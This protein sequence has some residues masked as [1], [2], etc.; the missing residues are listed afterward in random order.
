MPPLELIRRTP[1]QRN[2]IQRAGRWPSPG[3]E[4]CRLDP[5]LL[6]GTLRAIGGKRRREWEMGLSAGGFKEAFR[7]PSETWTQTWGHAGFVV[8]NWWSAAE[9]IAE[10][11]LHQCTTANSCER[12]FEIQG[13]QNSVRRW[14]NTRAEV[15]RFVRETVPA[16]SSK[17][18]FPFQRRQ[19]RG[20][21]RDL[22]MHWSFG[23]CCSLPGRV[24]RPRVQRLLRGEVLRIVPK[25]LQPC[26][27]RERSKPVQDGHQCLGLGEGLNSRLA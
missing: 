8:L 24:V 20:R 12:K 14:R 22:L 16:N 11:F 7:R 5:V 18:E 1:V 21:V 23:S 6:L 15:Q 25:D 2:G 4:A 13:R 27:H 3:D 9:T 19:P 10:G 17:G 26:R